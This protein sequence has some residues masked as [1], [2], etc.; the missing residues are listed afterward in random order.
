MARLAGL[1][2][3]CAALAAGLPVRTPDGAP[4]AHGALEATALL[5]PAALPGGARVL[6]L[7]VNASNL[8]RSALHVALLNT[9]ALPALAERHGPEIWEI[10]RAIADAV[11]EGIKK[12]EKAAAENHTVP[13]MD[14]VRQAVGEEMLGKWEGLMRGIRTGRFSRRGVR[15]QPRRLQ[16]F[17]GSVS[18]VSWGLVLVAIVIFTTKHFGLLHLPSSL[19]FHGTA[20]VLWVVLAGL[21]AFVVF[22]LQGTAE[23]I[24]W[25]N[26]YILELI[27]LVQNVLVNHVIIQAFR[28]PRWV[29]E[30]ALFIVVVARMVFQLVFYLGLA[31]LAFSGEVLPYL[32]GVWLLY[33]AWHAAADGD[34]A[35]FDI[36]DSRAV[37][38]ARAVLGDRLWLTKDETGAVFVVK[39]NRR[40]LSVVG[41][42][43]FC[44]VLVDGLL[45]VDV[46]LTKI[47]QLEGNGY[48]CFSSAVVA[49]F[50]M[51]ELVFVT[52]DLFRRCPGLRYGISLV[53]A[54][55]GVQMLLHQVFAIPVLLD[56]AIFV[57]LLA[58]SA[59]VP[60]TVPKAWSRGVD[61]GTQACFMPADDTPTG[62]LKGAKLSP[63]VPAEG[64][65]S[66]SSS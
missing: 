39:D 41:L 58:I 55:I 43:V 51:P 52:R 8:N 59:A 53:L 19:M 1:L 38:V 21:F 54:Y 47:E 6:L 9:S 56:S 7:P 66:R 13:S 25:L 63:E 18:R 44:L 2:A 16:D 64:T 36:M 33:V 15:P 29:N 4:E 65:R 22:K 11:E 37:R 45:Q 24:L 42:M 27:F 5:E 46:S 34:D 40:R 10:K 61:Q 14:A 32:L 35:G 57:G 12:A 30:K 48:L 3:A 31:E 23:A 62:D 50:C 17:F 26:G 28:T 20:L 60:A 49:S